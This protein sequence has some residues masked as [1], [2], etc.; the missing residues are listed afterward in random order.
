MLGPYV[1]HDTKFVKKN[2][3]VDGSKV[4]ADSNIDRIKWESKLGVLEFP[5]L[6]PTS[7]GESYTD[8]SYAL[9]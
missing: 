7:F 2:G 5:S 6:P 9:I 4:G 1:R 3:D 8:M